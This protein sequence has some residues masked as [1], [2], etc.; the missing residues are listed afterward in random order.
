MIKVALALFPFMEDLKKDLKGTL[1]KIK[2]IGYE[3]VELAYGLNFDPQVLCNELKASELE[4]VGWHIDK[5][6]ISEELFEVMVH[7]MKTV[8]NKRLI[9]PWLPD[10]CTETEA[11]WKRTAKEFNELSCRL[12]KYGMYLGYHNH[13]KEFTRNETGYA[14]DVFC[15][16]T[17]PD[18]LIQLDV[19]NMLSAGAAPEAFLSKYPNRFQTI[20]IK[21]YSLETGFRT[22]IGQ[23]SID[24]KKVIENSREAGTEWFVIEYESSSKYNKYDG[25]ALCLKEFKKFKL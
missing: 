20:H 4:L 10:S 16:N 13:Q 5:S 19:G 2:N 14:F 18:I 22:M 21:P 11:D 15:Q 24:Y 23:D 12:S 8:G 3:G 17:N 7:Y 25:V 1:K 6:Y 9:I